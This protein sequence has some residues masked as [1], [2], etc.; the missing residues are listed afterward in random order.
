MLKSRKCLKAEISSTGFD[1][2]VEGADGPRYRVEYTIIYSAWDLND[3]PEQ[4]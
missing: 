2:M 3:M 1:R 4:L